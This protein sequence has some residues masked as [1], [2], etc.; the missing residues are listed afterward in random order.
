PRRAISSSDRCWSRLIFGRADSPKRC[1]EADSRHR[2]MPCLPP[3]D[4]CA[5]A[6]ERAKSAAWLPDIA[7]RI[8]SRSRPALR[9]HQPPCCGHVRAGV[10]RRDQISSEEIFGALELRPFHL[11]RIQT[12]CRSPQPR[13]DISAGHNAYS[14]GASELRQA[15]DDL[16]PARARGKMAW[17]LRR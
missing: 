15:A 13:A 7:D 10:N 3:A 16:V 9:A 8:E 17:R 14:A 5:V 12:S 4:E 2:S 1:I 11:L 6:G